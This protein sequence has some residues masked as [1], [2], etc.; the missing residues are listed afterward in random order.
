ML[1]GCGDAGGCVDRALHETGPH[2]QVGYVLLLYKLGQAVGELTHAHNKG[3][4]YT[5]LPSWAAY[6]L[7]REQSA[8]SAVSSS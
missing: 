2:T 6:A 3:G 5:R 4:I 1:L 8:N 7:G